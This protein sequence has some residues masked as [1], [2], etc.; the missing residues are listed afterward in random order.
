MEQAAQ[1]EGQIL[2]INMPLRL[3]SFDVVYKVRKKL[4]I[5]KIGHAGTL[6][7]L[8]TGL[9]IICVGKKTKQIESFMGLDKEYT[10]TF[11]LGQTTPSFD[12]E[13]EVSEQ[14]DISGITPEAIRTAIKSLTGKIS[15]LPPLHSAV[16]I[17]GRRAYKFA[18]RGKEVKLTPR[19]VEIKEFEVTFIDL[20]KVHFRILCSK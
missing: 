20:P 18:R 19:D 13:T 4:K 17:G 2:L 7:P 9:L 8:A 5:K 12:R 16:K 10:G 15:Q 3:T 14:K 1:D 6:D 11:I